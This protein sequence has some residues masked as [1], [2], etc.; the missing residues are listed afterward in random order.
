M[1]L[2]TRVITRDLAHTRALWT[3]PDVECRQPK[4][5]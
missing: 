5:L 1:N 3:L 4:P 2:R